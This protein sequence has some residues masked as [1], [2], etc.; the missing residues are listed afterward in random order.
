M[1]LSDFD[2]VIVSAAGTYTSPNFVKV[3]KKTALVCYYHTPPRYLYGYP[4][5]APWDRVFWRRIL[6]FF[7]KI[8]MH[9]LRIADYNAAQRPD[10]VLANSLEVARRVKKFY[11]RDAKVVYPP[12]DIPKKIKVKKE[13]FYLTGGRLA[14]PKRIDLAIK[15]ANKLQVPLQVFGRDFQNYAEELKKMAGKTVK[16]VGEITDKEKWELMAKAKAFI[17]PAELEDFG[18]T[19]VEAM[20]V[21]TPVIALNSGGLKETVVAGKTGV[22]FEKPTVD[23]LINAIKD[24]EQTKIKGNNCIEQAEKFSTKRFIKE[25]KEVVNNA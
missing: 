4:T 9:L 21:G 16:F 22:L 19:P 6:Y 2:V 24:F 15:A 13:S 23:S 12:V 5:A 14:R 10:V 25:M 7:G 3:G 20:S 17:F 1:D 11:R 8:P 18:I